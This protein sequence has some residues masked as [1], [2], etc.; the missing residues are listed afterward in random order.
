MTTVP[1]VEHWL[2]LMSLSTGPS[3]FIR[4]LNVYYVTSRSSPG[5]K[6]TFSQLVLVVLSVKLLDFVGFSFLFLALFHDNPLVKL[7]VGELN[8][9]SQRGTFLVHQVDL[10]FG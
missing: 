2:V 1:G 7:L 10:A 6:S 4:F 8:L 5:S 9:K 3:P